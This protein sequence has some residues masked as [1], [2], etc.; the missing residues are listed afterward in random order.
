MLNSPK[1]FLKNAVKPLEIPT[2]DGSGQAVHPDIIKIK[3]KTTR[4]VLAFTPY[5][6]SNELYE[7]PSVL[8]SRDGISWLENDIKNPVISSK[9]GK[10]LASDPD[11]VYARG[12][13]YLYFVSQIWGGK[14]FKKA[15]ALFKQYTKQYSSSVK[16]VVSKDL[17]K[18]SKP[19]QILKSGGLSS[20]WPFTRLIICPSVTWDGIFKMWYIKAFGC[21]NTNPRLYYRESKDGISWGKEKRVFI[22]FP[23]GQVIWHIDVEKLSNGQYW[24]LIAAYPKSEHC[25]KI[26]NLY[27]AV[28]NDGLSW[29]TREKPILTIDP[30]SSWDSDSLYRSTFIVE[31]KIFKLWYTGSRNKIWKIGY[32]FSKISSLD[33]KTHSLNVI[34]I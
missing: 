26:K 5:P 9:S 22:Q 30:G 25:E 21:T 1:L 29:K 4:Y 6:F 23:K 16:V 11:I 19:I 20:F 18:W 33:E 12:K 15:R 3:G 17:K 32:T 10:E 28:S 24:M 2:F 14:L 31:N 13:F 34:N 8:V 7:K 27:L